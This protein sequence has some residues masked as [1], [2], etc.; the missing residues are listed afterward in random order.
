MVV[1]VERCQTP[2]RRSAGTSREKMLTFGRFCG[3]FFSLKAAMKT[4]GRCKIPREE[5]ALVKE[6][7]NT[8]THDT[9][10][11]PC[12]RKCHAGCAR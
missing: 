8:A 10:S 3:K 11:E 6:F 7:C 2:H 9:T 5:L 1:A 4:R 12:V